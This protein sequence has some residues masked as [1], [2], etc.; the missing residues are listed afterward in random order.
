MGSGLA[1]SVSFGQSCPAPGLA[2]TVGDDYGVAALDGLVD[3]GFG[4]VDCEQDR[5]HLAAQWIERSFKQHF[6]N[7]R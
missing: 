1:V 7:T 2:R 4:E 5:V 3:D 6:E